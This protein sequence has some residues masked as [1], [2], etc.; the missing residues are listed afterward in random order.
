MKIAYFDCF[1]GI[2]GDMVLGAMLDLGAPLDALLDELNKLPVEGYDIRANPEKRGAIGGTRVKI[3]IEPQPH[4]TFSDIR[5]LIRNSALSSGVKEKS[6]AVFERIA[7]AEARVHHMPVSRVHFHEV[8]AL[9]S[10]LDVVGS[11]IALEL[12]GI[13]KVYASKVPLGRGFVHTEHGILPVPAPATVHLLAGVPV[14]DNGVER[15]LVTPTGA[16]ILTTLADSFGPAPEMVLLSTGY[17]VGSHPASTPPNLLRVLLGTSRGSLQRSHLLLLETSID[18]MNPEFY[19]YILEELFSL[20][21][22]DVNMVPIQMK[23]NRPGILLRILSHPGLQASVLEILFKETTTLGVRI[24]EVDR[25]E[26]RREE[27]II[28]TPY[29]PCRVKSVIM[30]QGEERIIPEF[31]ECKRIAQ[32]N[33]IPLRKVYE[34][35]VLAAGLEVAGQ[36]E[37]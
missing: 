15:E 14:Y 23:K 34:D 27:K 2:S 3:H 18:D 8:G 5:S 25:V 22:L 26:L 21:V 16:G 13:E 37:L 12:L 31:E 1:S 20:G 19:N 17:G 36:D 9:D 7:E 28:S 29:G 10:I 6:L 33:G 30:P 24:Q 11:V 35:V 4:R 32:S